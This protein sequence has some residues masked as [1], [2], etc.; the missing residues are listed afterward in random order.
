M[1]ARAPR[2]T[3]SFT[4]V[5]L[6]VE[7]G[8]LPLGLFFLVFEVAV[9][10]LERWHGLLPCSIIPWYRLGLRPLLVVDVCGETVVAA[11]SPSVSVTPR[12]EVPF[13]CAF[14]DAPSVALR[15]CSS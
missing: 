13:V 12:Y 3:P 9:L 2:P 1:K 14:A 8:P 10:C 11:S 5:C 4:F 7:V 6:W 15:L